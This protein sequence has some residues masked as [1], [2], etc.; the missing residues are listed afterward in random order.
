MK[1]N[2]YARSGTAGGCI[3]LLIIVGLVILTIVRVFWVNSA[4]SY[5]DTLTSIYIQET[6]DKETEDQDELKKRLVE[7]GIFIQMH[8]W[9]K[10][11]FIK[12][13]EFYKELTTTYERWKRNMEKKSG[14]MQDIMNL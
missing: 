5:Y 6:K 7:D 13:E 10:K 14:V 11:A 1:K 9:D 8:K 12:D 2:K 4:N 3:V